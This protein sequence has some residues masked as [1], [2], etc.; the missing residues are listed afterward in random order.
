MLHLAATVLVAWIPQPHTPECPQND[1]A[2][3][4]SDLFWFGKET[5]YTKASDLQLSQSTLRACQAE[6][7]LQW[8][9]IKCTT[10]NWEEKG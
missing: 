6:L 2:S 9:Q 7:Q 1:M 10:I 4:T 8:R 5:L 3:K